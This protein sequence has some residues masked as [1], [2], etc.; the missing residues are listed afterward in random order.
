MPPQAG[1]GSARARRR[2]SGRP[3]RSRRARAPRSSSG[4]R[5]AL[6]ACSAAMRKRKRPGELDRPSPRPRRSGAGERVARLHRDAGVAPQGRATRAPDRG[7]VERG[8]GTTIAAARLCRRQLRPSQASR[9]LEAFV[10]LRGSGRRSRRPGPR[11]RRGGRSRSRSCQLRRAS[12]AAGPRP[13]CR[14]PLLSG[15]CRR[16]MRRRPASRW[17]EALAELAHLVARGRGPRRGARAE[18]AGER[19]PGARRRSSVARAGGAGSATLDAPLSPRPERRAR[20]PPAATAASPRAARSSERASSGLVGPAISRR[21]ARA[22]RRSGVGRASSL[23][24]TCARKPPRPS[25]VSHAGEQCRR[26]GRAEAWARARPGGLR[27]GPGEPRRR[28]LSRVG[29]RRAGKTRGH[30]PGSR[31]RGGP[32]PAPART[33]TPRGGGSPR[34]VSREGGTRQQ[35]KRLELQLGVHPRRR[36]HRGTQRRRD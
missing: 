15:E 20:G 33:A 32:P 19:L 36:L 3:R 13:A 35:P 31:P 18:G 16:V 30:A 5:G 25:G 27:R 11:P 9:M 12:A 28:A 23:D 26:A 29:D 6:A 21:P 10:R 7:P 14:R 24:E 34:A 1:A 2:G 17:R 4:V 22:T 8:G